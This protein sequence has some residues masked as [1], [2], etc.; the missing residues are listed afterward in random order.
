MPLYRTD[1]GKAKCI[2][3]SMLHAC[4]KKYEFLNS[5]EKGMKLH[6][7]HMEVFGIK[8]S[9]KCITDI[10]DFCSCSIM[11]IA[12]RVYE[13]FESGKTNNDLV[14]TICS[15]IGNTDSYSIA[16]DLFPLCKLKLFCSNIRSYS[17]SEKSIAEMLVSYIKN[18]LSSINE[19]KYVNAAK[20]KIITSLIT[21][22]YTCILKHAIKKVHLKF[23]SSMNKKVHETDKNITNILASY[24]SKNIYLIDDKD[25]VQSMSLISNQCADESIILY[26]SESNKYSL[27]YRFTFG[28]KPSC[29]FQT[30]DPIFK[31]THVIKDCDTDSIDELL[32]TILSEDDD[33]DRENDDSS[34]ND[35]DDEDGSENGNGDDDDESENSDACDDLIDDILNNENDE[36]DVSVDDYNE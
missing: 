33:R 8:A 29:V 36:D 18:T 12:T 23:E 32:E 2:C 16:V 6:Q 21:T 15:E 24:F 3:Q 28:K 10:Q 1:T 26:K 7:M 22:L 13:Y 31:T 25:N 4:D 27:V 9:K 35:I 19:L 14:K 11:K 30:K 20:Y 34:E 17:I 5:L